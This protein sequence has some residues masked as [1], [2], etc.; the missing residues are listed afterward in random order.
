MVWMYL[1][2]K[3]SNNNNNNALSNFDI[4]IFLADIWHMVNWS[5]FNLCPYSSSNYDKWWE[6]FL[7]T[8]VPWFKTVVNKGRASMLPGSYVHKLNILL[9]WLIKEVSKGFIFSAILICPLG[10]Y[11]FPLIRCVT[12][13]KPI[14]DGILWKPPPIDLLAILVSSL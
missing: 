4:H 12:I 2:Q 6:L 1:T 8:I 14:A 9:I 5:F 3:Q 10:Q 11:M 7:K 13:N